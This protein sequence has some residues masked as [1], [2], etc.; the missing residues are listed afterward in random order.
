MINL[1]DLGAIKSK[2]TSDIEVEHAGAIQVV[3][4]CDSHHVVDA[5]L[6]W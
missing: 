5:S 3:L 4:F 6:P 2:L 1:F